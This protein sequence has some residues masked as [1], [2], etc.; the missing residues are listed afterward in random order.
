MGVLFVLVEYHLGMC[1]LLNRQRNL[2]YVLVSAY[3]RQ[4]VINLERGVQ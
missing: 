1:V 3:H 4:R 2:G